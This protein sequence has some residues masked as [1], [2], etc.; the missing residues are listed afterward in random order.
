M[1]RIHLFGHFT[2]SEDERPIPFS[3][4]PKTR[5]LFAYLL[6]NRHQPVSRE[7]IAFLLWPDVPESEAKANLRRHLYDLRRI[8]PDDE[9]WIISRGSTLYWQPTAVYWLDIAHFEHLSQTNHLAE[10]VALYQDDLLID[11]YEDWLEAERERLRTLY[12][13][14]L[15]QLIDRCQSE[16]DYPQAIYYAQQLLAA[17]TL[18]EDTIRQLMQLRYESG[19]RAGALQVYQQFEQLLHTEL[20][21]RPMTETAALYTQIKSGEREKETKETKTVRTPLAIP[22]PPHNLPHQLTPFF[23]RTD[24]LTAISER[25]TNTPTRLLTLTGAGGSGKTRLALEAA[26]QLLAQQPTPFPDGIYFVDL[27]AVTAPDQIVSIISQ[28]FTLAEGQGNTPAG[29]LK[30]YLQNKKI[31]LILDNFEQIVKA[32]PILSDLLTA[33]PHLHLIVTSRVL[34]QLYGEHEYPVPPLPLPNPERLPATADLPSYAAIALFIARARAYQ[35]SFNLN[36]DNAA[37]IAQICLRLDGLPLAIELAAARIKLF[38]PS[39]LLAQLNDRLNILASTTRDRPTRQQTLRGAIDWS[40][41]LLEEDEKQLFVHLAIFQGGF[42]VNAVTAVL[43]SQPTSDFHSF[44]LTILDQLLSL[45][46]KS[47]IQQPPATLN[48]PRFQMLPL[49]R[50]YAQSYLQKD[51]HLPHLQQQHLSYYTQLATTAN[52]H[53]HTAQQSLWLTRLQTDELNF[54][55]AL[56]WSLQPHHPAEIIEKGTN[57]AIALG[58][59]YWRIR[60]RIAEAW[61][62]ACQTLA[63]QQTL[64]PHIRLRTFNQ[65]ATIAQWYGKYDE[66]ETILA[67]AVP[68]A[69]E[70]NDHHL[71]QVALHNLGLSAGR[72]GRYQE[73]EALLTEAINLR[74]QINQNTMDGSL[75][76][77]LNNLAIVVKYLGDYQRAAALFQECLAFQ[78]LQGDQLGAASVISNL[79][80]LALVQGDLTTAETHLHHS[81]QIR[82]QLGDQTGIISALSGLAELRQKQSHYNQSIQLYSACDTLHQTF[83]YPLTSEN[84]RQREENLA[85]LKQ[86]VTP[87]EFDKAWQTG[88]N[89][90]LEQAATLALSTISTTP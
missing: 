88:K 67:Q 68:L 44:D 74:R 39:A 53:L 5:P 22:R 15:E 41:H 1:L 75:A 3:A 34:L 56:T 79:G 19:D 49:L 83:N 14:N 89:L 80:K 57:L 20:G 32:A 48:E 64:S 50:E 54:R 8:L 37:A 72:Q 26:T 16:N 42:T 51:P 11:L 73:A 23:G 43:H 4:L 85:Q 62:W 38:A 45:A 29:Q 77:T 35:P 58:S 10:A 66:A 90:T 71:L 55:A 31:L 78:Q 12:M 24:D 70:L 33:A 40:Y 9:Q 21:V 13:S 60:G 65:A 28:L 61:Q 36:E 6:L 18:R 17:D 84:L 52:Q 7:A 59:D 2:L 81:L 69:R 86:K 82:Q 47:M 25:L 87:A 30:S 46:E 76:R 63:L 27:S